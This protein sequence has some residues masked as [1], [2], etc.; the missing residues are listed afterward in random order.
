MDGYRYPLVASTATRM[1][2]FVPTLKEFERLPFL[3]A[4]WFLVMYCIRTY[5][6]VK[7]GKILYAENSCWYYALV[8]S[9]IAGSGNKRRNLIGY[10][11]TLTGLMWNMLVLHDHL[12]T[13][14]TQVPCF[15]NLVVCVSDLVGCSQ[16]S[17]IM[18]GFVV[19]T[20]LP[21]LR[22]GGRPGEFNAVV[23][24][25]IIQQTVCKTCHRDDIAADAAHVGHEMIQQDV[26]GRC[27]RKFPD[28][29]VSLS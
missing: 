15:Y 25:D 11:Y 4:V 6:S 29:Y 9:A 21:I 1:G 18:L 17:T 16:F 13:P 28:E 26:C 20:I 24:H 2:L 27:D 7:A 3:Q 8:R 19:L 12:F 23:G 14:V 22:D 5:I 10:L